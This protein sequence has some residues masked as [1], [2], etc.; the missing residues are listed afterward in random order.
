[1]DFNIWNLFK[2]TIKI[3]RGN[4]KTITSRKQRHVVIISCVFVA[5]AS[6]AWLVGSDQSESEYIPM[7]AAGYR[8][9]VGLKSDGTVVAVGSSKFGQCDVGNWTDIVRVAAGNFHTVGLKSDGTVV[10]VGLNDSGQC[11][12]GGWTGI[13][14]IAAG[15]YHTVGVKFDGTVVA[16]GWNPDGQCAVGGWDLN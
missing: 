11:D 3:C 13:T 5:V 12:V 14:K 2:V 7:V 6:I 15:N 4:M 8:Y 16:V 9:T 1:L 10:A